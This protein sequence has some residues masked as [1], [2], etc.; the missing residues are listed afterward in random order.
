MDD[1][2]GVL[3]PPSIK[4]VG[5]AGAVLVQIKDKIPVRAVNSTFQEKL[6]LGKLVEIM[7]C[8]DEDLVMNNTR[9]D[10][11]SLHEA[12]KSVRDNWGVLWNQMITYQF[13]R[14]RKCVSLC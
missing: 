11:S 3:G 2:V 10:D 8:A 9:D 14:N 5:H 6:S 7:D 1:T 4:N 12:K 13:N